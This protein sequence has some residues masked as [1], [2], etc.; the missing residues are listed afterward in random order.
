LKRL[1]KEK[2]ES[3]V[4]ELLDGRDDFLA[5]MGG[6]EALLTWDQVKEMSAHGISFGSHTKTH[7]ILTQLEPEEARRE[8]S[9]SK[10]DIEKHLG[11]PCEA[12]AYPNGDWN[13]SLRGLVKE[14][15]YACACS[16]DSTSSAVGIDVYSLR[17]RMVHE[18]ATVGITGRFS[19]CVFA[20]QITGFFER[21]GLKG[22]SRFENRES[23][24]V[25]VP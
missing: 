10:V 1:P 12:F 15:G 5:D 25:K 13:P 14:N 19:R 4:R 22:S 20:L 23:Q 16:L 18:G 3:V 21:L 9:G 11:G 2:R 17:R 7:P 6:E 24:E 8:I